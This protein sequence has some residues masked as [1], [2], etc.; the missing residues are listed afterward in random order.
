MAKTTDW[1]RNLGKRT[2]VIVLSLGYLFCACIFLAAGFT[3]FVK[4]DIQVSANCRIIPHLKLLLASDKT[5]V[6]KYLN[7]SGSKIKQGDVLADIIKDPDSIVNWT[8]REYMN[9]ALSEI[10]SS[11]GELYQMSK[12]QVLEMLSRIPQDLSTEIVLSP[13][14]G[15]LLTPIREKTLLTAHHAAAKGDLICQIA[16]LDSA[17]I[18]MSIVPKGHVT[19][20]KSDIIEIRIPEYDSSTLTTTVDHVRIE[21]VI[22]IPNT[23]HDTP[24]IH[25]PERNISTIVQ[26]EEMDLIATIHQQDSTLRVHVVIPEW[27]PTKPLPVNGQ[28]VSIFVQELGTQVLNGSWSEV[29]AIVTTRIH[30]EGIPKPLADALRRNLDKGQST[31]EV[32]NC[33]AR[34]GEERLFLKLFRK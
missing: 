13:S 26:I 24:E 23:E 28:A 30:P 21:S 4:T 14:D 10:D 20:T 9:K 3:W 15:W 31:F 7:H 22:L 17:T 8:L 25:I 19:L 27:M 29:K 12:T 11:T 2:P 16:T 33:W 1:K 34:I 6:L 32:D 5:I 18:E